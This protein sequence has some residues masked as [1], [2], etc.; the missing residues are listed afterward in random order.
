MFYRTYKSNGYTVDGYDICNKFN[1]DNEIFIYTMK[2][3]KRYGF[4]RYMITSESAIYDYL[5][6][7]EGKVEKLIRCF[8]V[9]PGATEPQWIDTKLD[10]PALGLALRAQKAGVKIGGKPPRHVTGACPE[11]E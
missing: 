2:Q 5:V 4:C 8:L 6:N 11:D 1:R 9:P 7:E 10:T 3:G